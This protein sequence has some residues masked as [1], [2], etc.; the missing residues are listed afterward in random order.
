M[1]VNY[2]CRLR[3]WHAGTNSAVYTEGTVNTP[4]DTD[5]FW[6]AEMTFT[7][8]ALAANSSRSYPTPSENEV[9]FMNFGRSEQ[10]LDVTTD[11]KY[12]VNNDIPTQWWSWQPCNAIN[13]HLQ[14]RWGLVQ[15]KRVSN[16]KKF[17]FERWH[18]YRALFDTLDAMKTYIALNAKYTDLPEELDL[19]PYL[20]SRTCVEVPEIT[21]TTRNNQ[22][23]FLI[24]V[25]SRLLTHK[26][27]H[28]RS[29]RLVTFQ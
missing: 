7:F 22:T 26:P 18:I 20:L 21:L 5:R 4:G 25:K 13:L 11:N 6:T 28:I 23:D 29:D 19:P 9:W 17:S 15:F 1:T 12:V 27:A 14:D 2:D 16:D 10:S 24:T 3:E 8:E